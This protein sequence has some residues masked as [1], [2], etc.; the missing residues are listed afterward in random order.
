MIADDADP[1]GAGEEH[2]V[3]AEA[4]W[5]DHLEDMRL[6]TISGR[7]SGSG[8]HNYAVRLKVCCP[9]PDHV[10]CSKSRST[11][12]MVGE[13]GPN[14]VLCFLGS[15]AE[16][17]ALSEEEHRKFVPSLEDQRDYKARKLTLG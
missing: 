6:H 7:A 9:N 11:K 2:V 1:A 10:N 5:P 13:L 3:A 12:L 15:W 8:G 4:E 14:A 17:F 16:H